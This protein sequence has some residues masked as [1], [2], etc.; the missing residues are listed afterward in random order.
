MKPTETQAA[1]VATFVLLSIYSRCALSQAV[2]ASASASVP[3]ASSLSDASTSVQQPLGG[4]AGLMP[5]VA[6]SSPEA[7]PYVA[8]LLAATV[9]LL[10]NNPQLYHPNDVESFVAGI[11]ALAPSRFLKQRSS[12]YNRA[13]NLVLQTLA[14]RNRVGLPYL[15]ARNFPCDL[16]RMG[17]IFEQPVT[18]LSQSNPIIWLRLGA[19]GSIIRHLERFTPSRV[20]SAAVHGP[21]SGWHKVRRMFMRADNRVLRDSV[22]AAHKPMVRSLSANNE[23]TVMHV[24]NSIAWWLNEWVLRNPDKKATLIMDFENTDYALA[25]WTVGDFLVKLD[26]YFPDLFDQVIGFRY[27]AKIWSLHSAISMFTRIFKSKFASSLETDLKLRFIRPEQEILNLMPRDANG[28]MLP[29]HI[30]GSC[31]A[32]I[33]PPPVGCSEEHKPGGLYD[34]HFW[35]ELHNEFYFTCKVPGMQ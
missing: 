33:Y 5:G 25:S 9:P 27:K 21:S 12:D 2:S 3:A 35:Q 10:R 20:M 32:P 23:P 11:G 16:F 6:L 4:I 30:T 15:E 17:L 7:D 29:E 14:W 13:S 31:V 22:K 19:L 34:P 26:D 8:P 28:F 18:A 1:L 24:L